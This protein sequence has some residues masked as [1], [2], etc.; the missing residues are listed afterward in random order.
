LVARARSAAGDETEGVLDV[1]GGGTAQKGCL[2]CALVLVLRHLDSEVP[3]SFFFVWSRTEVLEVRR[4]IF[5]TF[6]LRP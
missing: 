3:E 5:G 1:C 2:F 4:N 6:L